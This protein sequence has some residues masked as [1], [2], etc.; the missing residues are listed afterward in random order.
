MA[1]D[2]IEPGTIIAGFEPRL[3]TDDETCKR[4]VAENIGRDLREAVSRRKLTVIAN[5]PSALLY[6][7]QQPQF[8]SPV[9]ALNGALGACLEHGVR[10]DYWA[11]CDPQALVADFLPADPPNDLTYLVASKCHPLVFDKLRG[12]DVLIWHLKDQACEGRL[13]IPPSC[14]VTMSAMWLMHR[15]GY[16]D[17]DIW[18]WDGCWLDDRHHAGSGN[19]GTTHEPIHANLG[20]VLAADGEVTGGRVFKTTRSWLAEMQAAEQFFHLADYFD[21]GITIHGDGMMRA[22]L[23]ATLESRT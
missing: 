19:I 13:R 18:G 9:L 7:G 21:L 14:S 11:A 10:P 15:M 5:G 22:A 23:N 20:G 12:R 16:T 8:L 3:P 4:H 2:D 6:F 1:L 17:F